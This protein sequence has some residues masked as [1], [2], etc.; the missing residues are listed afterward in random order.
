M[1]WKGFGRK[2]QWPNFKVFSQHLLGGTEKIH[3]K[4]LSE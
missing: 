1:N 4:K 2:R 3:K